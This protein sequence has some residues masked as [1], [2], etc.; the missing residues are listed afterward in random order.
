MTARRR[1]TCSPPPVLPVHTHLQPFRHAALNHRHSSHER[2]DRVGSSTRDHRTASAEP[3]WHCP[4][5]ATGSGHPGGGRGPA[6]FSRDR[7]QPCWAPRRRG[8]EDRLLHP[9]QDLSKAGLILEYSK[10][11]LSDAYVP[12]EAPSALQ[13]FL[14]F[15]PTRALRGSGQGPAARRQ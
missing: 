8:G 2:T 7:T 3:L 10:D 15:T 5:A 4:Q 12:T 14:H 9:S 11:N 13:E 1:Q 6:P